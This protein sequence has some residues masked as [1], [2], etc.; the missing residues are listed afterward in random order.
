MNIPRTGVIDEPGIRF[1]ESHDDP[2]DESACFFSFDLTNIKHGLMSK[3]ML[4]L[5]VQQYKIL[6]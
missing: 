4:F 5:F 6:G 1:D 2:F 3:F